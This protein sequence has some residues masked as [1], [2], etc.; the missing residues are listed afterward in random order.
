MDIEVTVLWLYNV[1]RPRAW[2]TSSP[3][4]PPVFAFAIY[5]LRSAIPSN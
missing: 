4:A 5:D 3:S 2:S 1:T